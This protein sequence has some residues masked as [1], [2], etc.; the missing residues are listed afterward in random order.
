M[1]WDN[2]GL[3][4]DNRGLQWETGGCPRS[5][6]PR[7]EGGA[8]DNRGCLGQQEAPTP[9]VFCIQMCV[10]P[11][12]FKTGRLLI[13]VLFLAALLLLNYCF[14]FSDVPAMH[15]L[16]CCRLTRC[17][18]LPQDGRLIVFVLLRTH[19]GQLVFLLHFLTHNVFKR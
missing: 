2:R 13:V 7:Q 10:L 12:I 9:P 17:F 3:P 4:W 8:Q 6:C 18:Q 1:P 16:K 11:R 5:G 19:P 15:F 14:C